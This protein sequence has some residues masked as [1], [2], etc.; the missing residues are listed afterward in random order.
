MFWT[1][2]AASVFVLTEVS[3]DCRGCKSVVEGLGAWSECEPELGESC[4]LGPECLERQGP[5][6]PRG[7]EQLNF[8]K[9][10][11]TRGPEAEKCTL[12]IVGAGSTTLMR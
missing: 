9:A 7:N 11:V 5:Q 3:F 4:T 12:G 10:R 6:M 2:E 1:M 8:M